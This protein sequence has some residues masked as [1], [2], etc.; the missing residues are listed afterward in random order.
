M[1]P[2]STI[3]LSAA[4]VLFTTF[5][6]AA[7][8]ASFPNLDTPKLCRSRASTTEE[9]MGDKSVTS[10]T[11]ETCMNSEQNARAALVAAWKDIPASYKASCVKSTV[12][13]PSYAE[14]ISCL[15]LNID[16]KNL[17]AKQ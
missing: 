11:Y 6:A 10:R 16:V 14:W 12:F 1:M 15:E 17:R 9:M 3:V 7:Q 2:K 4:A 8:D 5:A 13:S